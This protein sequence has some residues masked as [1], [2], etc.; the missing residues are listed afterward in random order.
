MV[1]FT[2]LSP[3]CMFTFRVTVW[4]LYCLYNMLHAQLFCFRLVLYHCF[5]KFVICKSFWSSRNFSLSEEI[6]SNFSQ[7]CTCWFSEMY[8]GM[9]LLL[10]QRTVHSSLFCHILTTCFRKDDDPQVS[11]TDELNAQG[12]RSKGRGFTFNFSFIGNKENNEKIWCRWA[13]IL[14]LL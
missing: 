5:I 2:R 7:I 11:L 4:S 14:I 13:V 6:L 3:N 10:L 9:I 12:P 1:I 8:G